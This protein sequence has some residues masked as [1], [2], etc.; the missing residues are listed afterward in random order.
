MTF[1]G[2]SMSLVRD[3][4]S[5]GQG[6]GRRCFCTLVLEVRVVAHVAATAHTG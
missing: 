2:F 4:N 6:S 1:I 3:P 5:G